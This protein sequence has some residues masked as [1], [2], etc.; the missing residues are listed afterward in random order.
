MKTGDVNLLWF[1]R[2]GGSEVC[3]PVVAPEAFFTIRSVFR[4]VLP[5]FVLFVSFCES[6]S[7]FS[8]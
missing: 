1:E 2:W 6:G 3:P 7:I 4:P 8:R 5:N